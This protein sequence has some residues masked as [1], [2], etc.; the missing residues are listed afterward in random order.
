MAAVFVVGS[1]DTH[2]GVIR[3]LA[4][5]TGSIVVGIDYRLA[6]EFKFPCPNGRGVKLL[7]DFI[8]ENGEKYDIDA[9]I[10]PLQV[11]RPGAF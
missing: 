9:I 1:I 10:S 2:D 4:N 6:P 8:R 7:A 11:T 5:E 3:R